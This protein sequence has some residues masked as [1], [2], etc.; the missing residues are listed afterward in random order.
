MILKHRYTLPDETRTRTFFCWL[1]YSF[2]HD[3]CNYTVWWETITVSERFLPADGEI[4]R[5]EW[6]VDK[7]NILPKKRQNY[8]LQQFI[9]PPNKNHH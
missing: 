3:G 7:W 8:I 2:T 1:P 9:S 6:Q 5:Y 4:G